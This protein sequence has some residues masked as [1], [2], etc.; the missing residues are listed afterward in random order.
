MR[1][2]HGSESY[3][4][5]LHNYTGG[6]GMLLNIQ[7]SGKLKHLFCGKVFR[8]YPA[9]TGI[10]TKLRLIQDRYRQAMMSVTL[11]ADAALIP[12]TSSRLG[13]HNYFFL[14]SFEIIRSQCMTQ[15]FDCYQLRLNHHR[16]PIFNL[17]AI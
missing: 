2:G 11:Y 17:K 5:I 1:D 14:T 3:I 12:S 4:Y 7:V 6:A 13:S 16:F 15:I 9:I 8:S 10:G